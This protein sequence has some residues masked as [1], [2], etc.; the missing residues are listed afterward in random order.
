[1]KGTVTVMLRTEAAKQFGYKGEILSIENFGGGH[2]NDTLKVTTT[3]ANYIL[4]RI[5]HFVFK[6]PDEIMEN[7]IGVTTYLKDKIIQEGG[8]PTRETLVYLPAEDGKYYYMDADGNYWRSTLFTEGT[9]AYI[10]ATDDKML[11]QS[12]LAYGKFQSWLKDYPAST[13]NEVIKDFHDTTVRYQQL[14]DAIENAPQDRKEMAKEQIAFAV[15]RKE[16]MSEL[17]A[18][19]KKGDLPLKVTHNDTK[20][21]NV[22]LD[23]NTNDAVCVIDLDTVMPGLTAFDFGD[24]IRAGASTGAE[25]EVDLSK[26]NFDLHLF[27]LYT[28]GFLE[29]AGETLTEKELESLPLGSK[30]MTYEVGI[31]FLADYLN[32]DVYFKT[33]YPEH[34]LD[35]AKNQFKLVADMEEKWGEM[36]EIMK[37]YK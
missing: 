37:K 24:S 7:I 10:F 1:M 30:T 27:E 5:N 22:L 35:R 16:P 20:L 4:Q 25:D 33:H 17:M 14:M 6:K 29:S 19:L 36:L 8:D 34:N 9:T 3:E 15:A 32:G 28:K 11:Y 12:G 26:V 18:M 21:S 31:R 2:I 23:D 13:L